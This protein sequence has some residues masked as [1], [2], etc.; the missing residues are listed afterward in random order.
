MDKELASFQNSS[1][2]E[3]NDAINRVSAL[4]DEA[5][6]QLGRLSDKI[7]ARQKEQQTCQKHE[8]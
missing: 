2:N 8:N 6:F 7:E 5:K 1:H 3:I 4:I